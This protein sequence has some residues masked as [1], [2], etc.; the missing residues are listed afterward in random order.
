MNDRRHMAKD[1]TDAERRISNLAIM[2]QVAEL[3]AARA[4]VRVKAG[5]ILTGWLPFATA[6][7]GEDRTWNAPEPGEQ[8]LVVAPCGDLNQGIVVGSVYRTDYPAPADSADIS[9][10]VYKDGAVQEYDRAGHNWLLNV[11]AGGSIRLCIGQTTLELRDDGT[12]LTTPAL[13]VD[14]PESTFTGT[15]LI[16][17]LLTYLAGLVGR[18]SGGGSSTAQ[19]EGDIR[20]V[21]GDVTADAISLKGHTHIEQGDGA[22]TSSAR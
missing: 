6:R 17:K 5:S 10:T 7:A 13:L 12:T 11:P 21:S 3:D 19:I 20:V 14:S 16:Q 15:V 18:S 1:M 9:R 4:R 8:V 22:P 2:G